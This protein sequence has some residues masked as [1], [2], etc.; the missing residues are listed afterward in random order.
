MSYETTSGRNVVNAC[1]G[2]LLPSANR[3]PT[4][5]KNVQ[6]RKVDCVD[7]FIFVD[8]RWVLRAPLEHNKST[9]HMIM[10]DV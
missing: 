10:F 4:T 8:G 1:Y 9:S 5:R 6:M 3:E 7:Q 2:E